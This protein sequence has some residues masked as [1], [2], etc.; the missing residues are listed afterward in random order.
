MS[1]PDLAKCPECGGCLDPGF[2]ITRDMY[3][4]DKPKG[5]HLMERFNR[6]GC[7]S[8]LRCLACGFVAFNIPGYKGPSE[9]SK[10]V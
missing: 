6:G 3:W 9:F 7:A 10:T 2:V 5:A 8:A 4:T 1:L